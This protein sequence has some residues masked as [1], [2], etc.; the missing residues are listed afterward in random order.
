MTEKHSRQKT[1]PLTWSYWDAEP[2]VPELWGKGGSVNIRKLSC[3]QWNTNWRQW[4]GECPVDGR[5]NPILKNIHLPNHAFK[6]HLLQNKLYIQI[7]PKMCHIVYYY[8][9]K[10]SWYSVLLLV[11]CES[12]RL[13]SVL[14]EAYSPETTEAGRRVS[15]HWEFPPWVKNSGKVQRGTVLR[16]EDYQRD[17]FQSYS[18]TPDLSRGLFTWISTAW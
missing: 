9:F 17:I 16:T 3:N 1:I 2:K 11:R 18:T 15:D 10:A 4:L 14:L 5:I 12:S 8:K 13:K 7:S 6:Q